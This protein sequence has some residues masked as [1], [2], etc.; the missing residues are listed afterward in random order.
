M[1]LLASGEGIVAPLGFLITHPNRLVRDFR[2]VLIAG[3][4]RPVAISNPEQR[5]RK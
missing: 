3:N 1:L 4:F 2:F 5:A